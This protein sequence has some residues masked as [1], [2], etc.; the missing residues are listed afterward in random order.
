MSILI[1][2]NDEARENESFNFHNLM[3]WLESDD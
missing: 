3:K 2:I 1:I